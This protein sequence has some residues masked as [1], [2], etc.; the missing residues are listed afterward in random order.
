MSRDRLTKHVNGLPSTMPVFH[1]WFGYLCPSPRARRSVRFSLISGVVGMLIGTVA[2]LSLLDK[3]L[4]RTATSE[5]ARPALAQTNG[6]GT[7]VDLR[8]THRLPNGDFAFWLAENCD[9]IERS[10]L[11]RSCQAVRKHMM[12]GARST[13]RLA[14]VRN[15]RSDPV[16]ASLPQAAAAI[17]G[18]STAADAGQRNEGAAVVRR[19]SVRAAQSIRPRAHKHPRVS[20]RRSH[21]SFASAQTSAGWHQY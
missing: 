21:N 13:S 19:V 11:D 18:G 6:N 3:P 16:Q 15:G 1:P 14:G 7:D 5:H 8:E 10:F 17:D 2:I 9:D 12:R 4:A 20:T